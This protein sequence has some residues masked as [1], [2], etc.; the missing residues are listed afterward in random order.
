MSKCCEI[1]FHNFDKYVL[2]IV[3]SVLYVSIHI[4]VIECNVSFSSVR[5]MSLLNTVDEDEVFQDFSV[6]NLVE[7]ILTTMKALIK[8]TNKIKMIYAIC[9]A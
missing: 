5:L 7:S 9:P 2:N 4:F 3:W 1:F 8:K 6:E